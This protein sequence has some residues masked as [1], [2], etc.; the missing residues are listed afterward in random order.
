MYIQEVNIYI[1]TDFKKVD[2]KNQQLTSFYYFFELEFA[3]QFTMIHT[4]LIFV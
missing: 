1:L 2:F 4:L 3:F